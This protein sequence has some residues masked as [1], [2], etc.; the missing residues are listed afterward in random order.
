MGSVPMS[1]IG[2][3]QRHAHS[4]CG[5]G[6][7][8]MKFVALTVRRQ[9]SE[10]N[11]APALNSL[12][13]RDVRLSAKFLILRT[14]CQPASNFDL[15]RIARRFTLWR[16]SQIGPPDRASWTVFHEPLDTTKSRSSQI[17]SGLEVFISPGFTHIRY[18]RWITCSLKNARP[19]SGPSEVTPCR[20]RQWRG[21]EGF[22]ARE[23][24]R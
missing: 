21:R 9:T 16:V 8:A 17:A 14:A 10:R 5:G 13:A 20:T 1:L 4:R 15:V 19:R 12:R 2:P 3:A 6:D 11:V 23:R 18:A 22:T 24:R 7:T